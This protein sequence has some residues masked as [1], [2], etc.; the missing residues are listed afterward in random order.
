MKKFF[1]LVYYIF[2]SSKNEMFCCY[3]LQA[4]QRTRG[5]CAGSEKIFPGRKTGWGG[6]RGHRGRQER[7]ESEEKKDVVIG[8]ADG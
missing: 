6:G 8:R 5:V 4:L 3:S 2:N 7:E 1:V